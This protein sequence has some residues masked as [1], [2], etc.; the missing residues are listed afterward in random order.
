MTRRIERDPIPDDWD[1]MDAVTAQTRLQALQATQ[2]ALEVSL[3]DVDACLPLYAARGATEALQR[4]SAQKATLLAEVTATKGALE[5]VVK[6]VGIHAEMDTARAVLAEAD[7]V[8]SQGVHIHEELLALDRA[9][10][11][12]AL[13]IQKVFAV[14]KSNPAGVARL[15]LVIN[16]AWIHTCRD[17]GY[18]QSPV[19]EAA[20]SRLADPMSAHHASPAAKSGLP[21]PSADH[22]RAG[23]KLDL[24][25]LSDDLSA[26]LS[27][28]S[29]PMTTARKT[30]VRALEAA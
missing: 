30:P 22:L 16:R 4:I 1:L 28:P 2:T 7:R 15:P 19:L 29:L 10:N 3:R 8:E 25:R 11:S 14:C 13:A 26:L 24:K 12:L 5:L 27:D 9:M 21:G 18:R 23:A 17:H 20:F 6:V